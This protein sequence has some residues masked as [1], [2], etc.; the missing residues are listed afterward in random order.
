ML[1]DDSAQRIK[2]LTD[3]DFLDIIPQGLLS[4]GV[5]YE[6]QY[7]TGGDDSAPA[8]DGVV[9]SGAHHP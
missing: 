9:F 2:F 1:A 8:P 6:I 7:V 4:G 5:T 3:F